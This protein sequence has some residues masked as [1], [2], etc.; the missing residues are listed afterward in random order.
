[1]TVNTQP[2][3]VNP[4]DVAPTDDV[5]PGNPVVVDRYTAAARINHW[6]TAV[7]LILLAL[8]GLALFHPSLFFLHRAVRRRPSDARSIPG[9]AWCCS[10]CSFAG[11]FPAI[12]AAE[13]AGRAPTA[14]WLKRLNEVLG[15]ATTRIPSWSRS[16]NTMPARKSCSGAWLRS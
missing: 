1:M 2:V 15:T 16:A 4:E 6:I 8:S 12:L 3:G 7:C 5:H 13:P 11:L 9:S 10:S 14:T